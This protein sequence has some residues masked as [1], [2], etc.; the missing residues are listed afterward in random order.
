MAIRVRLS[1]RAVS[2]LESI[3]DYLL[4]RSPKGAE[5]VRRAI[6][7]A[8]SLLADFPHLGR[9]REALG[10]RG[11]GVA[12]YPYTIYYR[13]E[14]DEVWIVHVR[15]DRHKPLTRGEV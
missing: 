2:D 8:I 7:V 9:E 14:G 5:N 13:I 6:D 15:D 12:R 4:S 10:V 11:F 1:P 3:R